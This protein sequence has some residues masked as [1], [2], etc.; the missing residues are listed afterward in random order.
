M[1]NRLPMSDFYINRLVVLAFGIAFTVGAIL[2]MNK[3][4]YSE[5][6]L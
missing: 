3:Q 2:L 5:G 4:N 1:N 6:E